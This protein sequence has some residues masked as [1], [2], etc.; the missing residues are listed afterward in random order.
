MK[1]YHFLD[2]WSGHQSDQLL[3]KEMEEQLPLLYSALL[4]YQSFYAKPTLIH[5]YGGKTIRLPDGRE[6]LLF[7]SDA[8]YVTQYFE[9]M[10]YCYS[11]YYK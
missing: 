5:Q 7:L 2:V 10:F 4:H 1:G 3:M 8:C 6:K 11:K 9:F